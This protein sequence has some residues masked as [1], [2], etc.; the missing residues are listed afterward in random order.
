[1]AEIAADF[2]ARFGLAP[3]V[4]A[5][6]PGRVNLLGEHTDYNEGLVLPV[7]TPQRTHVALR[8]AAE[9]AD[10][11]ESTQLA[12]AA[13]ERLGRFRAY[14]DGCLAALRDAGFELPAHWMLV[15]SAVPMGAGLSSSA[16]LEV[17]T[18]RA[19]RARHGLPLDDKALALLGQQAENR[20]VGVRSGILDQM[21]ASLG[22]SDAMLRLDTRS[23]ATE[24]LP[25][26]PHAAVLVLD[27]GVRRSLKDSAYN[28]RREEC[29]TAARLLGVRALRDCTDLDTLASLPPPLAQRARHVITEN[30]RVAQVS[31]S[32]DAASL[33]RLM[34]ASH[35]SLRRDFAVSIPALDALV[36]ALQAQPGVFGAKLTGAGFGGAVVA[37]VARAAADR[38][39]EQAL[40]AYEAQGFRGRRLL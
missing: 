17:A 12:H 33:G 18:L 7:A 14:L 36:A 35:E 22:A 29:E 8:V 23:L 32:T 28:Q 21:A 39:G 34:S 2:T 40:A 20:Y 10:R 15:D 5:S 11:F 6:A 19:L 24:L 9:G 31:A 4:D 16:A 38:A 13:P 30:A 27:S 26:P 37:L 25:L 3:E 1:M